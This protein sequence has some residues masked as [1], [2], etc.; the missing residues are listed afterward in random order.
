MWRLSFA[1]LCSSLCFGRHGLVALWTIQQSVVEEAH[2][3]REIV[4]K[5][6]SC[7]RGWVGGCVGAAGR[8]DAS[9]EA[10]RST[11]NEWGV[12]REECGVV[13]RRHKRRNSSNK[14]SG[15]KGDVF[16]GEI[17]VE[18]LARWVSS[19]QD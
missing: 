11:V 14:S 4:E 10:K 12:F 5:R 7:E 2:A 16:T 15:S 8:K 3:R 19:Q 6:G 17:V 18:K 13:F 1:L 9:K